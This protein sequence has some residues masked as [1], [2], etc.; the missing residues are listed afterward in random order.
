MPSLALAVD[1]GG[2]KVEAALVDAD[3]AVV[4]G[5]RHR[6]PTGPGRTADELDAA[7]AE[8]VRG[9]LAALPDGAELAGVG[10]GSA[11]PVDLA[12]GTVSPL[13]VPA[14]RGHP[15]VDRLRALVPGVPVHLRI[16]G[17]CIA[18]AEHWVGAGRDAHNLLGMI[19][20]TGVGGGLV[21]GDRGAPSPSGNGGHI[22]HVEVGGFDDPCPC[23][24]RGCLEA[25]ASGPRTVAWARTRGFEGTTGEDLAAAHAAGDPVAIA[26]VERAGRAIG[27]AIAS[28][29]NLVDLDVV[30]I[31][32]GFSR[33]AP[34][35]FDHARAAVA[36][37]TA[38]E[39]A[40]RVRI[41]PS[42]LGDEGPLIGAAALVHRPELIG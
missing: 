26:A 5:S 1:F 17:L 3:A 11:G 35:L 33:V 9:A 28:A 22:G 39:F 20:S 42:G 6:H 40:R 7:V 29:T 27:Q 38:F 15:L 24:G 25:I 31:G 4:P 13:N 19:V 34:A 16:D 2:T 23:G 41:V 21:L 18:L 32:G 14:W 30:A 10:L 8:V 36:E 12:A 37:R